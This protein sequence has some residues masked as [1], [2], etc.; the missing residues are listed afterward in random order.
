MRIGRKVIE[1]LLVTGICVSVFFVY[2]L[3]ERVLLKRRIGQIPLRICV[4]G[5]RGKSSVVRLITACLRDSRMRV[6]AKTTGSKPCLIFPDGSEREIRRRGNP[7]ILEGKKILKIAS[8][9]GVQAAVLEMM[10]IRPESL[11]TE[12][13]HMM[14]PHILVITNVRVDHVDEIGKSREENARCFASA[15]PEKSNVVIPEEE[16]Y[17]VFQQKAVKAKARL[18]V[19]PQKLPVGIGNPGEEIPASEFEQNF[20][21]A[22]AVTELLGE[23]KDK[24]YY[25]AK[26]AMPDF[27]GLKVWR[28]KRDSLLNGWYFV[29]AFAAND[30]ETTKD[31][32]AKMEK[33]GLFKGRKKIGLLNLR[34]DRGGRT[35]QWFDALQEEGADVFDRLVF[36]GEHALALRAKLKGRLKPEITAVRRKKP[37]DLIT[38]IAT[39]ESAEA[40]ILGMGN[41]G[42]MGRLMV[43]YWE[44]TGNR[45]DV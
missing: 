41:M 13:I 38:Q 27:G 24:A 15:I 3:V 14:K 36:V 10:S 42:G 33:R 8:R 1:E 17:P 16:L 21:I 32:L 7:T 22:L 20:R 30:P 45:H 11:H 26:Q 18:I 6:L 19:V 35:M 34:K 39:L 31:V 9:A 44:R 40:V 29:S 23:D 5:T 2:L 4:T 28:A 12:A 43:D 37:E 25:S